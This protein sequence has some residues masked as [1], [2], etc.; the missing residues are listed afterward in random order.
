M[1]RQ[2]LSWMPL[3]IG[4]LSP[5]LL[6]HI[7]ARDARE[8]WW[9][10]HW[11]VKLDENAFCLQNLLLWF[12]RCIVT[13][14]EVSEELVSCL[15]HPQYN[16]KIPSHCCKIPALTVCHTHSIPLKVMGQDCPRSCFQLLECILH[17]EEQEYMSCLSQVEVWTQVQ[18]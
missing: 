17:L 13:Q 9:R 3:Y 14:Q 15:I 2:I 6:I 18:W 10:V 12:T 16:G 1:V 5:N 11:W 7:W 4:F 8:R